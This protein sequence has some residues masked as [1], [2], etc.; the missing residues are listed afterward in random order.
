MAR[1]MTKATA[2]P[3]WPPM[4]PPI[5]TRRAVRIASSIA[6]LNMFDMAISLGLGPDALNPSEA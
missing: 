3:C 6:V 1:A 2:M 5:S 4:A